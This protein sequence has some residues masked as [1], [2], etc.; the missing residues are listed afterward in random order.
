MYSGK[1]V[2]IISLVILAVSFCIGYL[3]GQNSEKAKSYNV[4]IKTN[5]V[6]KHIQNTYPEQWETIKD[7][8]PYIEYEVTKQNR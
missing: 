6:F 8:R 3:V 2:A 5:K 7:S 1:S 4:Q